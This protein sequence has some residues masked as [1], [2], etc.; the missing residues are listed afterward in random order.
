MFFGSI[1]VT[2]FNINIYKLVFVSRMN[3]YRCNKYNW[4]ILCN[5]KDTLYLVKYMLQFHIWR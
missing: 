1:D 2:R 5:K 3:R 4:K